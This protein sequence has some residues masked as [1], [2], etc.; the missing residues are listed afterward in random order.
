MQV[1]YVEAVSVIR[2]RSFHPN[3][4]VDRLYWKMKKQWKG[5]DM[6]WRVC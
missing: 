4:D 2:Y 6:C 3:A 5:A 1:I